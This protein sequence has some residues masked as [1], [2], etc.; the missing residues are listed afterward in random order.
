MDSKRPRSGCCRFWWRKMKRT[1]TKTQVVP[2]KLPLVIV[3]KLGGVNVHIV[4]SMDALD[5]FPLNLIFGF[6]ANRRWW[7]INDCYEW[8]ANGLNLACTPLPACT[9][10]T[11]WWG[12]DRGCLRLIRSQ[13]AVGWRDHGEQFSLKGDRNDRVTLKSGDNQPATMSLVCHVYDVNYIARGFKVSQTGL[14]HSEAH[15]ANI[16]PN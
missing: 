14:S 5:D 9:C 4:V 7:N 11:A 13:L 2:R 12:P 10:R 1:L 6:L 16:S 8:P 3:W 15:F